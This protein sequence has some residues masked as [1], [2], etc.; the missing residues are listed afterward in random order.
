MHIDDCMKF[1][2]SCRPLAVSM[3]NAIKCIKAKLRSLTH[4]TKEE[5]VKISNISV[6]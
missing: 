3:D 2:K 4:D 5:T 1:L 6:L